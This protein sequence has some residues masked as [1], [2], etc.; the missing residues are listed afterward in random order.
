MTACAILS[1]R[2][3]HAAVSAEHN[4][5]IMTVAGPVPPAKLGLSLPHEHVLVD[6]IGA[7]KIKPGRYLTDDAFKTILPHLK[8]A[9]EL[10]CAS[11][12]ECTPA[13]LGRDALL[14]R[15]LAAGSGLH[16]ITNTGYYGA[17]D[18]KFLPAHAL[19]ETADQLGKR[20]IQEW[21][22]G[23][24]GTGVRPGFIKIGVGGQSLSPLHRK[25]VQAAGRTHRATGLTIASHTGPAN[26]A[27]EQLDTLK[28]EGIAPSAFI[29]VHAQ[30]E[31]DPARCLQV[32]ERGCWISYDGFSPK[33][34]ERY[35]EIIDR[36]QRAGRLNQLLLSHDAGWFTP[37]EPDGGKF[38]PFV[39]LFQTFFPKLRERPADAD[40][41][42]TETLIHQ[43]MVKNPARAFTRQVRL[44]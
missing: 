35:L 42:N 22:G 28:T 6:F 15:R 33:D 21:T 39:D 8:K 12:M 3:L 1:P 44:G 43:I 26:L 10:G 9:R 34:T 38:R 27:I 11:I 20:W 24:D 30:A 29:W 41:Q 18:N 25:L 32:A 5:S 36:L 2:S 40:G 7:D 14:L 17:S 13:Y 4:N 19:S 31:P 16:I 23:I 37:G